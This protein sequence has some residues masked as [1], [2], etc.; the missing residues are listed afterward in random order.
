MPARLPEFETTDPEAV[1]AVA[2][3]IRGHGKLLPL[4]NEQREQRALEKR[5]WHEQQQ[6][7]AERRRIE[8]ERQQAE[9]EAAA[10]HEAALE[11]AEQNRKSRQERHAQIEREFRERELRSLRMEM[12]KTQWWQTRVDAAA[13]AVARQRYN[14]TLMGQLDALINPPSRAEPAVV[15][16]G[17]EEEETFCGVKIPRWR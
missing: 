6:W 5:I 10:R 11:Q 4:S 7:L 9:T 12:T 1:A 13:N 17:P 16:V 14:E 8:R 2:D 3:E 15:Y